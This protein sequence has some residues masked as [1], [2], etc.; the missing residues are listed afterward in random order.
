MGTFYEW[1]TYLHQVSGWLTVFLSFTAV[2]FA[3]MNTGYTLRLNYHSIS[4]L[5]T[6]SQIPIVAILAMIAQSSR[7]SVT[8]WSTNFVRTMSDV[9]KYHGYVVIGLSQVTVS[10]GMGYYLFSAGKRGLAIGLIVGNLVLF[11]AV[12]ATFE[13]LKQQALKDPQTKLSGEAK[14][15][16]ASEFDKMIKEGRMLVIL[17]GYV[18]DIEPYI[19]FHPGGAFVLS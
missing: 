1:R 14:T 13:V 8:E 2:G 7:Y 12:I 18:L 11:A 6:A 4:G 17:E 5:V 19:A 10:L 9:H 16:T 3:Y 15:I